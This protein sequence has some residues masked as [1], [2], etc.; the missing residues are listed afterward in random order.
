MSPP[1][2][3]CR[4]NSLFWHPQKYGIVLLQKRV[5]LLENKISEGNNNE[6]RR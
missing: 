6:R 1:Y 2:M 3:T 4:E 5:V